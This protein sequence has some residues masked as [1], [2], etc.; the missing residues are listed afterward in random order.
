[1]KLMHSRPAKIVLG[2]LALAVVVFFL[3]PFIAPRGPRRPR[4][5]TELMARH[6][7]KA[8]LPADEIVRGMGIKPGMRILDAGASDGRFSLAMARLLAGSGAVYAADFESEPLARLAREAA[9]RGVTNLIP[10]RISPRWDAGFY[11]DKRFDI[12]L[13]N[14]VYDRLPDP[15]AQ[16]DGL[17]RLMN[18]RSA[19][20]FALRAVF[21]PP[22]D[23]SM[24]Y[25]PRLVLEVLRKHGRG[26]P[27]YTRLSPE[28]QDLVTASRLTG[29]VDDLINRRIVE[30]LN[31]CLDDQSLYEDLDRYYARNIRVAG[32]YMKEVKQE[33]EA[34]LLRYL[35]YNFAPAFDKGAA[36]ANKQEQLALYTANHLLLTC[37]FSL[38]RD[39]PFY[40]ELNFYCPDDAFQEAFRKAGFRAASQRKV[41]P[42]YM[43]WEFEREAE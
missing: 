18:G 43:L 31:R 12:V 38:P 37:I 6:R 30:F 15:E 17:S 1:M 4:P 32:E 10:V 20:L 29:A 5:L 28:L 19:H 23:A 33:Q 9:S 26:S 36:P 13:L 25:N 11:R 14:D 22:F 35:L 16:L 24:D 40:A 7:S 21:L 27:F 2:L 42:V 41:S 39:C 3:L 34:H 8:R